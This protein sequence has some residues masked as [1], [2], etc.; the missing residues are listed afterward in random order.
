MTP[1]RAI[2]H[3]AIAAGLAF[4]ANAAAQGTEKTDVSVSPPLFDALAPLAVTFTA[5]L[6]RLRADKDTNAPWRGAV[7]TYA[8]D[9]GRVALPAKARTRGIWR[10][11]N[12]AFPPL[13]L[14]FAPKSVKGTLFQHVGK[15]KL[16]NYCKDTDTYEQYVLQEFQLYRVFQLLSPV[17]YRVRLLRVTYV[18]SASG[19]SDATR[20]AFVAEDPEQLAKRMDGTVLKVEGGT[21]ADLDSEQL[22]V[23]YLFQFMIGNTDFSFN[24]LHNTQ[25]IGTK[26]GRYLPTVYD[27]DYAGAVDAVYATP[28]P[29]LR[30]RRVRDRK[31]RGYCAISGEYLKLLPRFQAQKAAI[32]ALYADEVGRLID[33]GRVRE[34]LKYFDEFYEMIATPETAQR[35]FLHDCVGP[36]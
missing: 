17:S 2:L 25:L 26:D 35:A 12:C 33:A 21:A 9:T 29:S 11:K 6:R 32:Y 10:L 1:P 3:A 7:I 23:A 22:A 34:T 27:F 4:P 5:D 31:F 19:K 14:Q 8:S 28:D 30:L 16:V 18:D 24:R 36:A 20:Y 15:P 13:R